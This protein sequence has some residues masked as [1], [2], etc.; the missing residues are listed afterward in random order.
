MTPGA[1]I[2][3]PL[4]LAALVGALP[5]R[6]DADALIAGFV[7]PARFAHKRFS[8][9]RPDPRHPSQA[10]ARERLRALAIELRRES[11]AGVLG[12]LRR[13]KSG[14]GTYLDGG[15]GVGKTH[16]LAALWNAAPA[17]KAYLSFDELVY[18]I[19]LLGVHRAREAFRGMRLVC[20]DEWELDDPGN[21]KLALAFLRGAVEDGVQLAVTSNT[22]PDELGRGRFSQKDFAREIEELAG[23]FE[24]IRIA[25]A[26]YRHRR[27]EA[28]AG[29]DHF[30]G[31]PALLAQAD[32][33]GEGVLLAGFDELMHALRDVHPIRYRALV[34]PL[35]RLLVTDLEALHALPDALRW[36]HFIDKLYDAGAGFAAS[37]DAA[38]GALFPESFLAGP[39]GKKFSR[40]LSRMEEL[41]GEAVVAEPA[42]NAG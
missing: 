10:A 12:R 7:P 16:L 34:A 1:V 35:S 22:V 30:A 24:V 26:D 20:V 21:L 37:S 8:A 18:T 17:P 14:A 31:T 42:P 40:C 4:S 32:A 5:A 2:A 13:R 29:R 38:L 33:D 23:A 25:G 28:R 39:F 27:F 11:G 3:R 41:L 36:V 9:Y 19:G 15:F 6:P